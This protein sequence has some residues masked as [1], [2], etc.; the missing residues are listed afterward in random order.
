MIFL[1]LLMCSLQAF[2]RSGNRIQDINSWKLTHKTTQCSAKTPWCVFPLKRGTGRVFLVK[3]FGLFL[4]P[5]SERG[6]F[7]EWWIP[8]TIRWFLQKNRWL[9]VFGTVK[10]FP[11]CKNC[12]V[13]RLKICKRMESQSVYEQDDTPNAY[14]ACVFLE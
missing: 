12:S 10:T 4:N 5:L 1:L 13:S 7:L 9:K 3:Q 2:F 14:K 8:N 11:W 6:S